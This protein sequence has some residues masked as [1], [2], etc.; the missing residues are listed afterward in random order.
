MSR[1]HSV[2][3]SLPD[4]PLLRDVS[5]DVSPGERVGLIG[6]NG[7]G[8]TTLLR[9]I[10]GELRADGGSVEMSP[11]MRTGHLRQGIAAEDGL[12]VG[13]MLGASGEGW[14]AANQM[15]TL[16][17]A[18]AEPHA[19][20]DTLLARYGDAQE[21]FERSG[22]DERANA[23]QGVLAGLGL[24]AIQPET[25]MHQMSGGQQTRLGLARLLLD[26]PDLLLLDEP[27][28][29]LDL[30]GLLWLEGFVRRFRGAVL[31]VSHDRVF[32]DRVVSKVVA[33][34]G[35]TARV[36]PGG[37]S[38]YAE[39]VQHEEAQQ[40]QTFRRQERTRERLEEEIR[41]E[42]ERARRTE[43]ST[44]DF[45]PR[46][47]A[48]KGARQ[49]KV[50]ER[51]LERAIQSTDWVDKP[52]PEWEVKLDFSSVPPGS[53]QVVVA[54]SLRHSYGDRAILQ[55]V[56]LHVR[57]G[58]RIV[59]TGPNG[60]GKSTLLRILAGELRPD[61]GAV[62]LGPSTLLGHLRQTLEDLPLAQSPLALV[63]RAAPMDETAARGYLHFFLFAGSQ[64][65]TPAGQLSYGERARL[66]LALIL[67]SGANFLLLDEPLNH[68]DIP[69]RE[70]LERALLEFPGTSLTVAH[71]RAFIRNVATRILVLQD[72]H[73]R[74]YADAV[75]YEAA[76]GASTG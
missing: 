73:V 12:T 60:G 26:A 2:D 72:G 38:A 52:R 62:R 42:Q 23:T 13:Q 75:A 30:A 33:I 28:N 44:I 58:E 54:E 66:N 25:P 46:A 61:G 3:Y 22:G 7:S 53:R 69:A 47:K 70:R 24:V 34:E 31:V 65:F 41:R 19:D 40:W 56:D 50:K 67:L 76:G 74:E 48:R 15:V 37:Y 18:M 71:D 49:A 8:K 55:G 9:I 11:G 29:H 27:T 59:L 10:D 51:R 43:L 14:V 20:L 32:L 6:R 45:A 68:L 16:G 1:V 17:A 64:V 39:A 63:R 4:R 5:F 35:G 57:A 21:R 36:Y